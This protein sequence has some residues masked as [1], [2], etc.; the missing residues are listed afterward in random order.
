MLSARSSPYSTQ[1]C[2][3]YIPRLI[4]INSRYGF[5]S[6]GKKKKTKGREDKNGREE[7][8]NRKKEREETHKKLFTFP[9]TSTKLL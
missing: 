6:T 7:G 1:N 4:I 3:L 2:L 5:I 9:E 8:K